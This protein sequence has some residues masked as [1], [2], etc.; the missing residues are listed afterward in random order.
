VERDP[1]PLAPHSNQL[2][3]DGISDNSAEERDQVILAWNLTQFSGFGNWDSW[4]E[5]RGPNSGDGNWIA[6]RSISFM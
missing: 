2:V 4:R 5:G 1:T 3:V 6:E